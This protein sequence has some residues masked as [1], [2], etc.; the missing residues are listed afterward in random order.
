MDEPSG[1]AVDA[2]FIDG[3]LR[4]LDDA[5]ARMLAMDDE[6]TSRPRAPGQWSRKEIV[7]HLIDSAVNNHARFVRAVL[8]DDLVFDGYDQDGWVRAQRYRERSWPA[9]VRVWRLL[10]RQIADVVGGMP[11]EALERP[12]RRHNL[13]EIAFRPAPVD[14]E[15]TLAYLIRDYVAHLQHHLA[16]VLEPADA[17]RAAELASVAAP[18]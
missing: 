5:A 4:L 12:R 15:A 8:Q 11:A 10:N 14:A 6:K 17:R 7:G 16:Q 2:D 1:S 9:L 3:F 13:H 18:D